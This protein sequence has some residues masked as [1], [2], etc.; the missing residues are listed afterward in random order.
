MGLQRSRQRMERPANYG[1]REN[2]WRGA[3]VPERRGTLHSW[4][5]GRIPSVQHGTL[6]PEFA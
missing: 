2:N 3:V 4:V 5:P 6:D 1:I